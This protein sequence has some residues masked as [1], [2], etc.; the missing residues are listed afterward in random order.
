MTVHLA[1]RRGPLDSTFA[2]SE[3]RPNVS[4]ALD[5]NGNMTSDETRTFEW[6]ARNACAGPVEVCRRPEHLS[7]LGEESAFCRRSIWISARIRCELAN[8][9]VLFVGN[10]LNTD[11]SGAEAFGIPIVWLSGPPYRSSDDASG[12]VSPT[13]TIGTL[14]ELPALLQRLHQPSSSRGETP[15]AFG[16]RCIPAGC[17]A[18]P[19]NT[20]G[21]LRAAPSRRQTR[22]SLWM[23]AEPFGRESS[24]GEARLRITR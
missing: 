22:H 15:D 20:A 24:R 18:P 11:I 12:D 16:R 21:I 14:Y 17:V 1:S 5:A 10:Q 2:V 3:R 7:V 4:V 13:Y 23:R 9:D 19:S 6:D 8:E